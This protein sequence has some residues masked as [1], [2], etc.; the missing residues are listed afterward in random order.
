MIEINVEIPKREIVESTVTVNARPIISGV[1]ASVDDNVGTPY[2]VV[3]STG[4]YTNYSFDLAFH[5]LKGEQ[6]ERGETGQ[7]GADGFSPSVTVEETEEGATVSVT[8]RDGTTSA[9]ILNGISPTASVSKSG[10][11]STLTVTDKNGTTS[12]EILDGAAGEITGATA[13]VTSTVGTPAVTVT[14]GGTSI[15]RTFDFAFENLKGDKG[16]TGNTGATGAD[17]FSPIATVSKSGTVTTI[18][19]T[20]KNGTTTEQ[21]LDGTGSISDVEVNGTSVVS[22]GVASIDLTGYATT[23]DLGNKQDTLVSGTNIKTINNESV[24]GSGNLETLN[25]N[26]ISNC[27]LEAP[28]GVFSTSGRTLTIKGGVKVLIPDGRNSDNTLKNIEYTLQN[29]VSID[30]SI[31][32]AGGLILVFLTSDGTGTP[33]TMSNLLGSYKYVTQLPSTVGTTATYYAYCD[34]NNYWYKT[35]GSTTT[36]WQTVSVAPITPLYF[37]TSSTMSGSSLYS[38]PIKLADSNMVDGKWTP[39]YSSI[40]SSVSWGSTAITYS[41]SDYLP[42]DNFN[43]EVLIGSTITTGSSSGNFVAITINNDLLGVAT[44]AGFAITRSSASAV[45]ACTIILPVSTDRSFVVG[46]STGSSNAVGTYSLRA[47]AYRR[48]GNNG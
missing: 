20:D 25:N 42:R 19:I 27:I 33:V 29:D 18:S 38:L 2:V 36:N 3:S 46:A 47:V 7:T 9:N 16:D 14:S 1:T 39:K 11:T 44:F 8:D 40:A 48:I 12:T 31:Y 17:G 21:V 15:A 5:N 13:S 6:G 4:T 10:D 41:L 43:Y 28:N 26:Q 22:G 34:Y 32:S 45:D 37:A 24:L 30:Y 23:S 35:S